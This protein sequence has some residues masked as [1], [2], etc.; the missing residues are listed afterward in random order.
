MRSKNK[1][2]PHTCCVCGEKA[3]LELDDGQWICTLCAQIQGEL[4]EMQ[5]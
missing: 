5:D 1:K 3:D 2:S 4:A